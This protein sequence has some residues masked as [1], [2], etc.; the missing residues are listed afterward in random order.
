[1]AKKAVKAKELKLGPWTKEE[2]LF[3]KDR[4]PHVSAQ[5]VAEALNRP[6]DAVKKMASRKGYKKS[7]K[8]LKTLGR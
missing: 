7:R 2:L 3:L 8:Y 4:W 1:M 6:T 5:A